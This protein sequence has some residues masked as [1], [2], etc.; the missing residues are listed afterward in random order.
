MFVRESA[1]AIAV[2][3]SGVVVYADSI[4]LGIQPVS[5]EVPSAF[6][7]YQNYPNPFNSKTVIRYS[8]IVN[9][10]V[11][12]R[13]YDALG[14]EVEILVNEMLQPGTYEIKWDGNNYPSGVY[15]YKLSIINP[16]H[17]GLSIKY[18]ETKKML[19]IK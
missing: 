11:R 15:F 4:P 7:L 9:G 12:L 3:D 2:G 17:L 10:L 5:N 13:V 8:L 6:L 14:R 18:E 19:L 1:T 16:E